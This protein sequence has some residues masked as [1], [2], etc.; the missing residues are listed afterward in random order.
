M[1]SAI[2]VRIEC[3]T[4]DGDQVLVE[5]AKT[6]RQGFVG[7]PL[8]VVNAAVER[9]RAGLVATEPPAARPPRRSGAKR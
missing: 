3:E 9:V 6:T 5:L 7:D 1:L 8:E 2:R 4:T